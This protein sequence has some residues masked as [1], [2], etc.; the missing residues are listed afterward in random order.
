MTDIGKEFINKIFGK[1]VETNPVNIEYNNLKKEVDI[2]EAIISNKIKLKALKSITD[3]V[4]DEAFENN[5]LN[6]FI[7]STIYIKIA[8]NIKKQAFNIVDAALEDL[9]DDY[10]LTNN[11]RTEVK[12]LI[13][14]SV[15]NIRR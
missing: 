4:L 14:N 12:Y 11:I 2:E 10:S 9:E 15:K 5:D 1:V 8:E 6:E 7:S 13:K 3:S